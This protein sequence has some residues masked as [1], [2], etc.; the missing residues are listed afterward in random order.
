MTQEELDNMMGDI[1]VLDDELKP[2]PKDELEEIEQEQES[3]DE[4]PVEEKIDDIDLSDDEQEGVDESESLQIEDDDAPLPPPADKEHK[5]VEQLDDVTR[6]SEIK[7][8]QIVDNLDGIDKLAI[9]IK[10]NIEFHKNVIESNVEIFEKLSIKF[11]DIELFKNSF[12]SNQELLT[13][14]DE[15]ELE[16]DEIVNSVTNTVDIMQYQDIHRQKIERVINVMRALSRYM[17]SLF[18]SEISDK[19]RASSAKTLDSSEAID[20]D[21]LEALLESFAKK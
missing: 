6:D 14:I 20:E 17:N 5:V 9:N 7:A 10:N 4:L 16:L 12:E 3:V 15:I 11:H 21:E 2:E 8:S 18:D 13:K 1:E 19:D